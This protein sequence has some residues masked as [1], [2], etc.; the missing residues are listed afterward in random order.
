[1]QGRPRVQE[2][3]GTHLFWCCKGEECH[4]DCRLKKMSSPGPAG[5]YMTLTHGPCCP[6]RNHRRSVKRPRGHT[7]EITSTRVLD[8][9]EFRPNSPANTIMEAEE[10]EL[11][12]EESSSEC[13][14]VILK[15]L[16]R[17]EKKKRKTSQISFDDAIYKAHHMFLPKAWGI[18]SEEVGEAFSMQHEQKHLLESL[19]VFVMCSAKNEGRL[20]SEQQRTWEAHIATMDEKDQKTWKAMNQAVAGLPALES[21]CRGRPK[22]AWKLYQKVQVDNMPM[23]MGLWLFFDCIFRYFGNMEALNYFFWP[24]SESTQTMATLMFEFEHDLV[25]S[26]E[27]CKELCNM[28]V[29]AVSLHA[30]ISCLF[31][32]GDGRRRTFHTD[33][34]RLRRFNLCSKYLDHLLSAMPYWMEECLLLGR[35]LETLYEQCKKCLND[36]DIEKARIAI[37][38]MMV[39]L[40]KITLLGRKAGDEA[41]FGEQICS[42][43][44]KF[45]MGDVYYILA[46][47]LCSDD[48][49]AHGAVLK[50]TCKCN[51]CRF[52]RKVR[53]E[54]IFMG[55]SPLILHATLSKEKPSGVRTL[56]ALRKTRKL[57]ESMTKSYW[58]LYCVQMLPCMWRK[59][60]RELQKL[61]SDSFQETKKTAYRTL[62][63][64]CFKGRKKEIQLAKSWLQKCELWKTFK[65]LNIAKKRKFIEDFRWEAGF[66]KAK[67]ISFMQRL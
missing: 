38:A 60:L 13:D 52:L 19:L 63:E 66:T 65:K 27:L 51:G 67:I 21:F 44:L 28:I 56:P 43:P 53:G 45:V 46:N 14:E 5:D 20:S 33:D 1:M 8:S 61:L 50:P 26:N 34:D 29:E 22:D 9:A 3:R 55:P 2:N 10:E 47:M 41:K 42:Y 59:F 35:C 39:G 18:F 48:A 12:E 62:A 4:A 64:I 17:P 6:C 23:K 25:S 57:L 49:T 15:N 37:E 7:D 31:Q 11:Y 24:D 58:D 36:D 54:Y 30:S 40:S 32:E 16:H